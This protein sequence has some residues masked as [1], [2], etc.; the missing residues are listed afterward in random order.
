[1]RGRV[2]VTGPD[3]RVIADSSPGSLGA[4]FSNR[5][6]IAAALHRRVA[7]EDRQ[8][9]TLGRRILATAVPIRARP[10]AGRCA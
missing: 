5:P 2:V 8:S 9:D 1:M 4:D 10:Q 6:E 3:G 7:Q